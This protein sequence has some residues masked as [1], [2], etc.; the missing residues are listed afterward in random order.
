MGGFN[1][2]RVRWRHLSHLFLI[3]RAHPALLSKVLSSHHS[4]LSL[5]TP[6]PRP[7]RDK[8]TGTKGQPFS[9]V[10]QHGYKNRAGPRLHVV[11]VP[12]AG[13]AICPQREFRRAPASA[14]YRPRWPSPSPPSWSRRRASPTAALIPI[15]PARSTTRSSPISPRPRPPPCPPTTPMPSATMSS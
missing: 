1:R 7:E 14:T 5:H 10:C 9:R 11:H 15:R 4:A 2:Q 8:G 3:A 6:C 13:P 12:S